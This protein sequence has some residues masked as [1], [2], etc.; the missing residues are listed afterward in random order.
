MTSSTAS[1]R[2]GGWARLSLRDKGLLMVALPIVVMLAGLAVLAVS[3]RQLRHAEERVAHTLEV[4]MELFQLGM[5]VRDTDAA[6][7][8]GLLTGNA[9]L[10]KAAEAAPAKVS[11]RL[12]RLRG[13]VSDKREQVDRVERMRPL[14]S[15]RLEVLRQAARLRPA[16]QPDP[17][18]LPPELLTRAAELEGRI[19][20]IFDEMEAVE[21]RLLEQRSGQ[22]ESTQRRLLLVGFLAGFGGVAGAIAAMLV[23][24][25]GVVR[26]VRRVET[27]AC[28]I[29]QREEL[30]PRR[31]GDDELGRLERTLHSTAARLADQDDA[32]RREAD[33]NASFVAVQQAVIEAKEVE[34]AASR[35]AATAVDLLGAAGCAVDL[36]EDGY[37]VC[38]SAVGDLAD[39]AGQ[40]VPVA[41]SRANAVVA[42]GDTLHLDDDEDGGRRSTLIV[43]LRHDDSVVGTFTVTSV[44]GQ[45]MAPREVRAVELLAGLLGVTAGRAQVQ[46]ALA[47]A[48][49]AADDANRAKSEFLSR[50]SHELRTPLN[51]ILGFG[52]LLQL[53]GLSSV[54]QES[55]EQIM[56][57]GRHLLDL[58]NEVLDISRIESGTM[59]LSVEPVD[60]GEVL[61]D[62]LHLVSTLAA[63][64]AVTLGDTPPEARGVTVAADRQ[65]L[66]QALLNL[67][68]NA[69]KYN[70][71][72]G[73][74]EV[75][76]ETA[77]GRVRLHVADTGIG[78][79]PDHLDRQFAPFDRL[80][81]PSAGEGSGLGRARAK[82]LVEAMGGSLEVDTSRDDGTTFTIELRMAARGEA[83]ASA[84]PMETRRTAPPIDAAATLLYVEDNALNV[85]LLERILATRPQVRLLTAATGEGGIDAAVR[86]R[87]DVILLDLHLPDMD[88]RQ[89][90]DRLK[91]DDRTAAIPV[92][93]VSADATDARRRR[94]VEDGAVE[95]LT[96]PLDVA[97]FLAVVDRLVQPA[98]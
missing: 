73:R 6:V 85:R 66:K 97:D 69:I 72:N 63:D 64:A 29:E 78:I 35:A 70:R 43:P 17:P 22:A 96:K 54:Q 81:A 58:I 59:R 80:G 15:A 10:L 12:A 32:L 3:E 90:L 61:D 39:R 24:T 18:A 71:P 9:E 33:W 87:P 21:G 50:M 13:L 49:D 48:R 68:A 56:R 98:P 76:C 27:I 8:A 75:A 84:E 25:R 55:V 65:R 30:P 60:V 86:D 67:L 53:D 52:Q 19:N 31:G 91:Q 94:L 38:R 57:G 51:A 44:P 20:A 77:A 89:V 16:G 42:L 11:Q 26:G 62:C 93:V 7:A 4:R 1:P 47:A 5:V 36:L 37:L 92:V 41:D 83:P 14:L 45:V 88:G 95:Y 34:Q 46:A 82:R 23:F 74:A 2:R 79:A 28:R 40:R